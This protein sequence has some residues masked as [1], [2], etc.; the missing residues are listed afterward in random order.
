MLKI[1]REATLEQVKR[2]YRSLAISMHPDKGGNHKAFCSL[3]AAFDVLQDEAERKAYDRELRTSRSRDGQVGNGLTDSGP[4]VQPTATSPV[5]LRDALMGTAPKHWPY[6][7]DKLTDENLKTLQNFLG[8]TQQE[9]RIL[10]EEF[11]GKLPPQHSRQGVPGICRHGNTYM[12]K[13]SMSG[14]SVT[15]KLAS[16]TEAIDA[17]IALKEIRNIVKRHPD[18]LEGGLRAAV[19]ERRVTDQDTIFFMRF[20]Y[21]FRHDKTIRHMTPSLG[22]EVLKDRRTFQRLVQCLGCVAEMWNVEP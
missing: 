8:L 10:A 1:D 3:Q 19:Q 21:D 9:Q 16:L 15:S 13:I 22:C 4:V 20:R 11:R 6:L 17:G 5:M 18:D 7:L 2:A 14:I 12:A